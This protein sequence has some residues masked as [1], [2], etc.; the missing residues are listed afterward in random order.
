MRG[1]QTRHAAPGGPIRP[2]AAG[3]AATRTARADTSAWRSCRRQFGRDAPRPADPAGRSAGADRFPASK[4]LPG[5]EQDPGQSRCRDGRRG[6]GVVDRGGDE[7]HADHGHWR[8]RRCGPGGQ[9]AGLRRPLGNG[10]SRIG[11]A[12]S[13]SLSPAASTPA[14]TSVPPA[15]AV[16]SASPAKAKPS[17]SATSSAGLSQ[18]PTLTATATATATPTRSRRYNLRQM[19]RRR[20]VA[21]RYPVISFW[22]L[23]M[24]FCLSF[25]PDQLRFAACRT[26]TWS[27]LSSQVTRMG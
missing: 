5:V 19:R 14:V 2:A 17:R 15:A 23:M 3:R 25:M 21:Y 22:Y 7:R 20:C 8:T 12:V 1:A 24:S 26:V 10:E 18:T 27:G 6:R 4:N 13:P 9:P 16:P 11:R